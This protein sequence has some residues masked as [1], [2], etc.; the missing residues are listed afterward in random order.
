MLLLPL[1]KTFGNVT[2]NIS[3]VPANPAIDPS[4]REDTED[5]VDLYQDALYDN[6]IVEDIIREDIPGLDITYIVFKKEVVQYF[7][8]NLGE[9]YG[10][11]STLYQDIAKDIFFNKTPNIFFCTSVEDDVWKYFS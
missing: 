4:I 9:L 1:E 5:I 8:D 11:H 6:P 10:M 3:V 2:L 7:T